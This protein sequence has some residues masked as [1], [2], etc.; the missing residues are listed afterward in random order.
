MASG[1]NLDDW[2]LGYYDKKK[3]KVTT[4]VIK[5]DSIEVKPEEDVFKKEESEVKEVNL[6]QAKLNIDDVL[7]KAADFQKEK[8][9]KEIPAKTILILQNLPG[10]GNLWNVTYVTKA[11][12]TLNMKISSSTGKMLK[13]KLTPLMDFGSK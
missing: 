5:K 2:Q 4:F 3:D 13:H 1:K 7:K 9:S 12:K 10:L 8:F 6:E 11:F